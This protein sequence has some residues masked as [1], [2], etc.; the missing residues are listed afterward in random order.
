MAKSFTKTKCMSLNEQDSTSDLFG[1]LFGQ[2]EPDRARATHPRA[3]RRARSQSL[4][5]RHSQASK[6]SGPLQQELFDWPEREHR[7]PGVLPAMGSDTPGSAAPP[8]PE[9][10]TVSTTDCVLAPAAS[11]RAS[12]SL[13]V[14]SRN[15]MHSSAGRDQGAASFA[16]LDLSAW[17]RLLAQLRGWRDA[18]RAG[19]GQDRSQP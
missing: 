8:Q 18:T 16:Q 14:D 11:R 13:S 2:R 4:R 9:A 5:P 15:L 17:R 6:P 12:S 19:A 3:G 1:Q 10:P 7:T